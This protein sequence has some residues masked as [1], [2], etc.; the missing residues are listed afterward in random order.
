[1][2]EDDADRRAKDVH[3][4][5]MKLNLFICAPMATPPVDALAT[6]EREIAAAIRAAVAGERERCARIA[7]D[8]SAGFEAVQTTEGRGWCPK[9]G[10]YARDAAGD[11]SRAIREGTE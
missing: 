1:M 2:A 9:C 4:A 11:I 6:V 5:L 8:Y 7:D 3:R 10:E